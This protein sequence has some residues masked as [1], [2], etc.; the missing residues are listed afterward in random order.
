MVIKPR[1]EIIVVDN[2]SVKQITE[3]EI[4]VVVED[5]MNTSPTKPVECVRT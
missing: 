5:T 1:V 2:S 4:E 3:I